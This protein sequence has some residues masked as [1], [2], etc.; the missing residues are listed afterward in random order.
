M[1]ALLQTAFS[2]APIREE[3]ILQTI[4]ASAAAFSER[5]CRMSYV[6]FLYFQLRFLRKRWLVM[7]GLLLLVTGCLLHWMESDYGIRRCLG[8]AAPLFAV[9]VLPELWKNRS[10]EAM[11]IESA[12][13]YTLRQVYAARITLFA[14]ADVLLLG[15]FFAGASVSAALSAWEFAVQF[16][17]P[18][19]VSCCICLVCLYQSGSGSELVPLFLCFVWAGLWL[20]IVLD[21]RVFNKISGLGWGMLL[22]AS[23]CFLGYAILRGQRRISQQWEARPIWN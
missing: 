7:Q 22:A 14:G 9:L 15:A 16:L 8:I 1:K 4:A 23:G 19:T 3:K 10:S 20:L 13:L 6:E 17:F 21:D 18:F 12:A 2:E 5:R 11:E